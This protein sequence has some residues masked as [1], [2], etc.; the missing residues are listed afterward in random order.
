[1]TLKLLK[2]TVPI[3]SLAAA[4]SFFFPQGCRNDGPKGYRILHTPIPVVDALGNKRRYHLYIPSAGGEK[5]IPLMVY[6]HGV[7]SDC[8][9]KNPA[10]KG[11]TGSPVEETGLIGL[12]KLHKMALLVPEAEYE[13]MFLNCPSR[14]WSPFE[15]EIDGIEK[16]IDAVVG[17]YPIS[18]KEIYLVGISAGAVLSHHL[19]NR[20]PAFYNSILS[21][22]QGYIAEDNR[23]LHPREK[24]PRF[25]VVFCYTRGDYK[26][27][28][29][30]CIDSEKIY[31]D[32]GYR[33]I[34]LKDLPPKN[35]SWANQGNR[36]FLRYL[37]RVGQFTSND[38]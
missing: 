29:S 1:M 27:L 9:K 10:L 28:V 4:V 23:L 16:M 22:S 17:H 13:Y 36:R 11:Y 38:E 26:N 31:R 15:K 33:T 21:H 12:C 24:G 30:I 3:L 34:L 20:R 14:G 37:K 7:R 6:F 19:A 35:H 25:G 2:I 8:F 18:R 32:K 5:K